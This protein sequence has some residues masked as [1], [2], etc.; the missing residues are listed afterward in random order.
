[1]IARHKYAH[2]SEDKDEEYQ[3]KR[4]EK[5]RMQD[6]ILQVH[7]RLLNYALNRGYSYI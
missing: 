4:E 7:L 6:D 5:D 3:R 2:V 1:M